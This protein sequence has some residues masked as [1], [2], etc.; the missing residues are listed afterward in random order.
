MDYLKS[1]N[2]LN[3]YITSIRSQQG[4]TLIISMIMLLLFMLIS[5][6][7][8]KSANFEEKMTSNS[9][10]DIEIYHVTYSEIQAHTVSLKKDGTPFFDALSD[11]SKTTVLSDK[12]DVSYINKNSELEYLFT[13]APPP[14]FSLSKDYAGYRYKLKTQAKISNIGAASTQVVGLTLAAPKS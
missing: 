11:S 12:L 10:R 14:Q 4:A 13:G 2:K 9:Q 7:G 3:S 6:S 5:T 8:V 1:S